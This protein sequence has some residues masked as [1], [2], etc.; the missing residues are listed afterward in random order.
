MSKTK[1]FKTESD[2]KLPFST[3]LYDNLNAPWAKGCPIG[4]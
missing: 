4:S 1:R 3:N 2:K